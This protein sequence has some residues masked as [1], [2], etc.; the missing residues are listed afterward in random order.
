MATEEEQYEKQKDIPNLEKILGKNKHDDYSFVKER[1]VELKDSRDNIYGTN[2]DQLWEKADKAYVP[3]RLRTKGERVIATDDE[4]GWRGHMITIGADDW[5]SDSSQPNPFVKI[6]TALSI[7]IDRNPEGVFNANSSRYEQNTLLMQSLYHK[8]W[9]IGKS[10]QQLKLF[11]FN[12]AKYGWACGKTYPLKLTRNVKNI[13][14]YDEDDPSKSEW[15]EKEV[16]EYNDI[17][18]ENLDPF[19]VWIDDMARPNNYWSLRDWVHRKVYAWDLAEEEFSK[20]PLWKYVKK[21]GDTNRRTQ[22]STS[23][24]KEYSETD[25]VE[26]Y[27]YENIVKDLYMVIINDIPVIIEPLPISNS[28]G[29]KKLS[30]WHTYWNL[31]HAETPYGIGI[32]EAIKEDQRLLDKIRNM[33]IDQL[34]LSIYKMFFYKGTDLSDTGEIKITPG[35]GKQ[36]LD[37]KNVTWL[38]IAG[39]GAEAWQGLEVL[40]KDLDSASGVTP[41]LEGEVTGKTA[42]EIA[43][44]KEAALKKLKTPLDNITD[45]LEQEALITI[46]LIQ[47]LYSIPEVIRI[48]DKDKVEDYLKEIKSDPELWGRNESG[49]F[50]AKVFRELQLGLD[51]DEQNRLIETDDTRFFRVKPSGLKWEG[52]ITIKGQ[53]MLVVSKELQKAMTLEFSNI[54]SPL[55]SADPSLYK[56]LAIQMCKEYEKDPKEWLPDAWFQEAEA[57]PL[58]VPREQ[59]QRQD[60]DRTIQEAEAMKKTG[61][62]GQLGQRGIAPQT[63]APGRTPN[64]LQKL[65]S[66]MGQAAS[67]VGRML[68][69]GRK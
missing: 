56:K 31:R 19:N 61:Q 4:K 39:P 55:L 43:Q 66:R 11:I 49:E 62:L 13:V 42:F 37:P 6:Q 52:M 38:Q 28:E 16:V 45:A 21:G 57:Q 53:S 36:V 63:Q 69:F 47:L 30:L 50:E 58:I 60:Q 35:K 1:I 7:L 2:L 68:P 33:T 51:K 25:L 12:L 3:H 8:N 64:P 24:L 29:H 40:K 44:A 54:I 27:F 46:S 41:P 59:I 20:Y 17:F 67:A 15:E 32:Y 14:N 34:V 65:T 26:V 18:R 22:S 48:T 9:E 10:K 23:E 5:Q